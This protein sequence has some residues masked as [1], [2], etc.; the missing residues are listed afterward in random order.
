MG[1]RVRT[2]NCPGAKRQRSPD[3]LIGRADGGLWSGDARAYRF[4]EGVFLQ[5]A[6]DHGVV[7]MPTDVGASIAAQADSHRRGNIS[8]RADSGTT[9]PREADHSHRPAMQ[10]DRCLRF[11]DDPGNALMPPAI[12]AR[13]RRDGCPCPAA[14]LAQ[15]ALGQDGRR[16]AGMVVM[17]TDGM[18]GTAPA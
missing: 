13:L 9:E 4:R 6:Y 5:P 8:T 14:A 2:T 16:K 12:A 7:Q 11:G 17:D 10:R 3:T 18:P 15:T 1:L